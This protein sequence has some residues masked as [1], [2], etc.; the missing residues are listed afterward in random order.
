MYKQYCGWNHECICSCSF[1]FMITQCTSSSEDIFVKTKKKQKN[2]SVWMIFL[3]IL[4]GISFLAFLSF[5]N[6]KFSVAQNTASTEV[7]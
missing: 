4:I 5:E 2:H 1:K 6:T 3:I 7:K